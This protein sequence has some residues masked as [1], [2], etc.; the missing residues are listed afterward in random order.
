MTAVPSRCSRRR[1]IRIAAAGFAAA[2]LANAL[3]SGTAHA[4]DKVTESDPTASAL[5]YKIDA[6][7]AANRKDA[8]ATCENCMQYSGKKGEAEGPCAIFGGKLVTA[9]GWCTAWVKKV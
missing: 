7:K 5:G 6:T 1:F 9:K 2:P 8:T 4:V 3:L